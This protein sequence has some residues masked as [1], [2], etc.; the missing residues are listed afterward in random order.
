M[1]DTQSKKGRNILRTLIE[2]AHTMELQVVVEGLETESQ[3]DF[4]KNI[5]G[6]IAQGYYY[7]RPVDSQS[8]EVMIR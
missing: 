2:L 5:G 7:S 6:C 4:I 8:Y 1:D 3:R